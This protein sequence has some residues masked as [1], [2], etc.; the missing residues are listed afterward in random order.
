VQSIID[1]KLH[2]ISL[3]LVSDLRRNKDFIFD[4]FDPDTIYALYERLKQKDVWEKYPSL[5]GIFREYL[6]AEIQKLF[7]SKEYA[8]IR[9]LAI[10]GYKNT[11]C[12][13]D[14]LNYAFKTVEILHI[15][16]DNPVL[17]EDRTIIGN[18]YNQIVVDEQLVQWNTNGECTLHAI[19][20]LRQRLRNCGTVYAL[21]CN[22]IDTRNHRPLEISNL[23]FKPSVSLA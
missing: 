18:L 11:E 9:S 19:G 10:A 17:F 13:K 1:G 23:V 21:V 16:S 6:S 5:V 14:R 8:K 2:Y 7:E 22:E 3:L 4:G 12:P 15:L 20:L